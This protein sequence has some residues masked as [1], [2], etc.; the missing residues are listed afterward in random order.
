MIFYFELRMCEGCLKPTASHRCRGP[1]P[2]RARPLCELLTCALDSPEDPTH[3]PPTHSHTSAPR[4]VITSTTQV[5]HTPTA[6]ISCVLGFMCFCESATL[7]KPGFNT[8]FFPGN[9]WRSWGK[10]LGLSEFVSSSV[11]ACPL[12]SHSRIKE[13]TCPG[14]DAWQ[15]ISED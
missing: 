1:P 13:R 15:A 2:W 4:A 11:K 8:W 10:L 14:A 6:V 9:S 12:W 5:G 3:H 7:M